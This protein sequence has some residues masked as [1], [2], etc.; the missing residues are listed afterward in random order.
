MPVHKISSPTP[1]MRACRC[2]TRLSASRPRAPSCKPT[3]ARPAAPAQSARMWCRSR[4]ACLWW[5]WLWLCHEGSALRCDGA[6]VHMRLSPWLPCY[7]RDALIKCL[8]LPAEWGRVSMSSMRV[9]MVKNKWAYVDGLPAAATAAPG[10]V[11]PG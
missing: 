1:S 6:T 7:W 4:C 2:A 3:L 5:L 11:K 10:L 9:R 8:H